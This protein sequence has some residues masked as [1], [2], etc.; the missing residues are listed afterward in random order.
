VEKIRIAWIQQSNPNNP[1]H[2]HREQDSHRKKD[3]GHSEIDE[4][5]PKQEHRQMNKKLETM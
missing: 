1:G 3:E 4:E 5:K 2:G